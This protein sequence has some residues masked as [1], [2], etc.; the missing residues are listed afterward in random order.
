[1]DL[2]E[3]DAKRSAV[4]GKI[5]EA[6]KNEQI[7]K[8]NS[9][10]NNF[11]EYLNQAVIP[12]DFQAD[13]QN[14][15]EAYDQLISATQ[16]RAPDSVTDLQRIAY[17]VN[18]R[19]QVNQA[20]GQA[21]RSSGELKDGWIP[22]FPHPFLVHR[23]QQLSEQFDSMPDAAKEI[24]T[25]FE[26]LEQIEW[27]VAPAS[28]N[29]P[30]PAEV[31]DIEPLSPNLSGSSGE[32]ETSID[33][34]ESNHEI[35][36]GLRSTSSDD[37][38]QAAIDLCTNS[39]S[40]DVARSA[41]PEL[42]DALS[43]GNPEV[44]GSAASAISDI[45]VNHEISVQGIENEL[46][47][48]IDE[49]DKYSKL[50]AIMALS[51]LNVESST[52]K[53]EQV[54]TKSRDDQQ[55]WSLTR[56]ALH[57]LSSDSSAAIEYRHLRMIVAHGIH[58]LVENIRGQGIA[59]VPDDLIVAALLLDD[60]LD[61]QKQQ[62]LKD[63]LLDAA[64]T[65]PEHLHDILPL[66]KEKIVER[67]HRSAEYAMWVLR[68]YAKEYPDRVI[69]LIDDVVAYLEPSQG[70]EDPGNAT[71]FLSEVVSVAPSQVGNHREKIEALKNHDEKYVREH[72]VRILNSLEDSEGDANT[73]V[74][75]TNLTNDDTGDRSA[76]NRPSGS[77]SPTSSSSDGMDVGSEVDNDQAPTSSTGRVSVDV[78]ND[79]LVDIST[80]NPDIPDEV[81]EELIELRK[82]AE[83]A[84]SE[85]PERDIESTT[86][87][88]YRRA[89]PI[90]EYAKRRADGICECCEEPAPFR[91]KN[92]DPYL[93]SHHVDEL[94]EG[95]A[96]SPD[97]VAAI[98][99]N[100]HKRIHHGE[101]GEILN[102]YLR[103]K[104]EAGLADIGK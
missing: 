66:L 13:I 97:K 96:D 32:K 39:V 70:Y 40:E 82:E 74:A 81:D 6:L 93:E 69:H 23:I 58:I 64:K 12:S 43:S 26:G 78:E 51:V 88:R 77:Q 72:C 103:Q 37:K 47:E 65:Q 45:V 79:T 9:L 53:L 30:K 75:S 49:D 87:S 27:S 48:I 15:I 52:D 104:L 21:P 38:Y 68:N 19:S 50:N 5:E 73:N 102:K 8:A 83:K 99:P 17:N 28:S 41:I 62:M 57:M 2:R 34:D 1:L 55:L 46:V 80:V 86:Q 20:A 18:I 25:D 7:E 3:V 11:Y 29:E 101:D 61:K 33:N 59:G 91:N 71:G 100:C 44:Q 63:V 31:F 89:S 42:K 90:G 22:V 92:G 60:S 54:L 14:E 56:L 94:G 4:Y 67:Q 35:L 36:E 76:T 95:G 84:A 10:I 24:L 16:E 98:C 85:N